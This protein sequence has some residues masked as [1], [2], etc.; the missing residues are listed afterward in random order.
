[1]YVCIY[2]YVTK[3][4]VGVEVQEKFLWSNIYYIYTYVYKFIT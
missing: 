3:L 1:M 4:E 2:I